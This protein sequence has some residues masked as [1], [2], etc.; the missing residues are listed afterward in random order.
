M[1]DDGF[2]VVQA[3]AVCRQLNLS[4]RGAIVRAA[5]GSGVVAPFGPGTGPILMDN[6]ACPDSARSLQGCTWGNAT[7]CAHG[8]DV[9]INCTGRPRSS[10]CLHDV[11]ALGSG[12]PTAAVPAA[13]PC[14]KPPPRCL[15][16]YAL[17][18]LWQYERRV[19]PPASLL[20]CICGWAMTSG[21][22]V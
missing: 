4:S 11:P 5:G 2:G 15:Q 16:M 9:G 8:E 21:R 7:D 19:V 13:L 1:C 18:G 22:G 3:S 17:P 12:Q 20:A 10:C 6:L 14:R